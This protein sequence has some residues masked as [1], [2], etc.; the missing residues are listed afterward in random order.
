M[1]PDRSNLSTNNGSNSCNQKRDEH[2]KPVQTGFELL[3]S[4]DRK[5]S[6]QRPS[7]HVIKDDTLVFKDAGGGEVSALSKVRERS[8]SV[9]P[10]IWPET[11]IPITARLL[12]NGNSSI[13]ALSEENVL[14]MSC[15]SFPFSFTEIAT[16]RTTECSS[17]TVYWLHSNRAAFRVV[18]P[19]SMERMHLAMMTWDIPGRLPDFCMSAKLG[20]FSVY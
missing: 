12:S 16:S 9:M 8:H 14:I 3:G 20:L 11:D 1:V 4:L 7:L 10:C 13:S 5:C 19:K 6:E 2:P 15:S 18:V 17:S